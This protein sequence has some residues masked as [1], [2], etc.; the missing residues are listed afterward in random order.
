L[1]SIWDKPQALWSH[2]PI[3]QAADA[4][5]EG[6]HDF[7]WRT[8]PPTLRR[9]AQHEMVK[10]QLEMLIE[11]VAPMEFRA[12]PNNDQTNRSAWVRDGR[13]KAL[14]PGPDE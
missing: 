12:S 3:K 11:V 9:L 13:V 8:M 2:R 7:N 5:T 14:A 1:T 10:M 6:L 4:F